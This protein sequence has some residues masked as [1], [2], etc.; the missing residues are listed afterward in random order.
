M[1]LSSP[2][3]RP[4]RV[5]LSPPLTTRSVVQPRFAAQPADSVAVAPP[6]FRPSKIYHL[7]YEERWEQIQASGGLKVPKRKGRQPIDKTFGAIFGVDQATMNNQ[8]CRP[9]R[10]FGSYIQ[11]MTFNMVRAFQQ[12]KRRAVM[13]EVDLDPAHDK[14]F[15]R[16]VSPALDHLDPVAFE[17][18]RVPL[19]EYKPQP[20][21]IPEVMIANDV[22][23]SRVRLVKV[24][25]PKNFP[26]WQ[27]YTKFAVPNPKDILDRLMDPSLPTLVMPPKHDAKPLHKNYTYKLVLL[28][29][30]FHK[31]TRDF[32]Y[33]NPL[34]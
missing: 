23:L 29:Y 20:H 1:I 2:A 7:T 12:E 34:W 26:P 11:A 3:I 33:D 27:D 22:P 13:L 9:T 15:V 4:T 10:Y 24:L 21:H 17:R 32:F 25:E 8:W 14:L 30:L 16:D 28:K 6:A 18:S 5:S 19:A 31:F